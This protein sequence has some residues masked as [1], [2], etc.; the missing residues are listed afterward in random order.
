[1]AEDK[2]TTDASADAAADAADAADADEGDVKAASGADAKDVAKDKGDAPK[3]MTQAE[4]DREVR[5]LR[6]RWK[7]EATAE[8][9]AAGEQARKEAEEAKLLEDEKFQELAEI[10]QREAED[11]KAKLARYEH[12]RN[13]NALL[14]KKEVT[15]PAFRDMFLG[16]NGEL[17]ELDG[18]IDNFNAVFDAAVEKKVSDRLGTDPPPKGDGAEVKEKRLDEMSPDEWLEHK[19]K[20]NVMGGFTPPPA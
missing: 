8:A 16:M 7:E 18:K 17:A 6:Q 3:T 5:K 12:E 19:Q 10:K 2:D 14:T 9:K 15:E 1:M 4:H 11:A 13:V 20:H